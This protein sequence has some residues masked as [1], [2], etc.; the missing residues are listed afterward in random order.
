VL[1]NGHEKLSLA[2]AFV[3]GVAVPIA[4]AM[5]LAV[6]ARAGSVVAGPIGVAGLLDVRRLAHPVFVI[7]I[8]AL[9]FVALAKQ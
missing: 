4:V 5:T 3:L 8:V 9:G 7:V 6:T 1:R 2:L